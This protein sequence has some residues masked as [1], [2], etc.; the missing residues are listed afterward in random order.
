MMLI[1]PAYNITS[2]D[3]RN[4]MTRLGD[5]AAAA[6]QESVRA[7]VAHDHPLARAV[8]VND[9]FLNQARYDIEERCYALLAVPQQ[10][11]NEQMACDPRALIGAVNV[12]T[13]LERIGD[14]AAGIAFLSLHIDPALTIPP[15]VEQ[16]GAVA[17]EMIGAAVDAFLSNNDLL[18]EYVA[19][20]DRELEEMQE[21]IYSQWVGQLSNDAA[22]RD[23]T[24]RLLWTTYKLVQIGVCTT[25][26]CERTIYVTTGELKEFR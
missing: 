18:A 17:H 2:H 13:N 3:L 25:N 1:H 21:E 16:M 19:R 26:I 14:L 22:L 11:I 12:A 6:I 20:R 5:M 8:S 23:S 9:G 7:L 24:M 4:Q 15:L 10:A